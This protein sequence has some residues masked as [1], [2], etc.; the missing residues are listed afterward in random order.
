MRAR[1][2]SGSLRRRRVGLCRAELGVIVIA[3][4]NRL[5]DQ[6]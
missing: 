3:A 6:S 4:F 5:T 2:P 1:S